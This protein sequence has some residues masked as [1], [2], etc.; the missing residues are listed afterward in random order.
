HAALADPVKALHPRVQ[1]IDADS[2]SRASTA[3][4]PRV[5]AL[6]AR[7]IR[8][9]DP[10][11]LDVWLASLGPV[12]SALVETAIRGAIRRTPPPPPQPRKEEPKVIEGYE[13]IK[14]LG[15][16]GIGFVWLVRKPGADRYFV[17]KIPKADALAS[18]NEVEREGIL[19]SFVEE[20]NA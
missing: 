7:A 9:R 19:A 3:N 17:L 8:A 11:M 14:G 15:E 16:G 5:A 6:V 12:A 4:A 20:A 10:A 2:L 13:L 1:E 18:A